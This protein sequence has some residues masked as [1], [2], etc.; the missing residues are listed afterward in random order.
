MFYFL[1]AFDL[2]FYFFILFSSL[3]SRPG[4]KEE[5][6]KKIDLNGFCCRKNSLNNNEGASS[7]NFVQSVLGM[8]LFCSTKTINGKEGNNNLEKP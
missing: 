3:L 7:R 8:V 4:L 5:I 2:I 1:N 6:K